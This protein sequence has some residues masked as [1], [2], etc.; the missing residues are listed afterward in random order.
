MVSYN[1]SKNKT[2]RYSKTKSKNLSV[3]VLETF[4]KKMCLLS[5][6]DEEQK[7]GTETR[8]P[9]RPSRHHAHTHTHTPSPQVV[10]AEPHG[11]GALLQHRA[12]RQHRL[13]QPV[14]GRPAEQTGQVRVF[15]SRISVCVRTRVLKPGG[16]TFVQ[17]PAC[18]QTTKPT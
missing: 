15:H 8:E 3:F 9:L 1:E 12:A 7:K 2:V 10:S 13:L 16:K 11:K 5:D 14:P 17:R 18:D 4:Q 6:I